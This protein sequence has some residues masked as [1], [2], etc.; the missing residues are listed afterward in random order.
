M[1]F[2]GIP[3]AIEWGKIKRKSASGIYLMV[4][5]ITDNLDQKVMPIDYTTGRNSG[6]IG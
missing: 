5:L 4:A 3:V 2:Q 6:I 1:N